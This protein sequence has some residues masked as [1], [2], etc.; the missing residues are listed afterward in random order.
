[1]PERRALT[2]LTAACLLAAV[3]PVRAQ[4]GPAPEW[5]GLPADVIAFGC[6]PRLVAAPPAAPLR[7]TGGQDSFLRRTY[8]PGDLATINGGSRHGIEVGQ[9]YYVRR[10][11]TDRRVRK[12]APVSI[13]T[14]GWIRVYAVDDTM[15][16]ATVTHACDSIEAGDYLEPF[17]TPVVPVP[18]P[19]RPRPERDNY[20]RVLIGSDRRTIFGVGDFLSIDRGADHGVLP[21]M[22][23]VLYRDKRMPDNF[24]YDL[25]EAVAV[26]VRPASATL[27]VTLSRD[28][29][30]EGDYAAMRREAPK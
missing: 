17:A 29:I 10:V 20:G 7:V 27:R 30:Q 12:G 24:L 16:L 18:L 22:H 13:Q 19:D 14:T 9:E 1:M 6:A 11:L 23:F 8:A 3:P 25:G 4:R 2:L 26:D 21:G 5:T 15:S 28:A